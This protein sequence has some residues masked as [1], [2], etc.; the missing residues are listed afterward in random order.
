MHELSICASIADIVRRR[1][2]Q[3]H[4]TTIH[5]RI[6]R[7]RQIVPETLEYCWSVLSSETELDG[8]TLDVEYVPARITCVTCSASTDLDEL[9][10]FMCSECGGVDVSVISGEEFLV[11]ALDLAGA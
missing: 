1:A 4:V 6:G 10:L 9:P 3:R 7:L 5:L 8:S 2:Q 11:T